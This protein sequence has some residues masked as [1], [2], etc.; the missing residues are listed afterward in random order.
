MTRSKF[1]LH[2][3]QQLTRTELIALLVQADLKERLHHPPDRNWPA[4]IGFAHSPG[5]VW[6]SWVVHDVMASDDTI[7]Q[8]RMTVLDRD[9][10]RLIAGWRPGHPELVDAPVMLPDTILVTSRADDQIINL[11]GH[12]RNVPGGGPDRRR[13]TSPIIAFDSAR[14]EWVRTLSRFY[15]L[16]WDAAQT[17]RR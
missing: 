11:A 9:Q 16:E 15:R 2:L 12:V 7:E 8:Q 4:D 17:V 1:S 14:F 10:H 5:S 13:I 6:L 3:Q